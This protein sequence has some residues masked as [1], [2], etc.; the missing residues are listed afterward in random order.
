MLTP[1]TT[2][3][4]VGLC[5]LQHNPD[6]IDITLGDLIYDTAAGKERDVDVTVTIEDANGNIEAFKAVE[7]KAESKPLDVA[8]IEQLCLKLSDMPRVTQ[9][10]IFSRSGFTDGAISKAKAHSV[11]LYTIMPWDTPIGE[12]LL[13]FEGIGAPGEFLSST[14]SDL[15]YWVNYNVSIVIRKATKPIVFQNNTPILTRTGKRHDTF[16]DIQ[17]FIDTILMRSTGILCMQEPATTILRTFP[18]T[19]YLPDADYLAGPAWPHTHTIDVTS[20]EAYIE[21]ENDVFR[22]DEVTIAGNLQWRQR[23]LDPEFFI[24][25]NV[26][27]KK[28]FAG[29]AI[30]DY[31]ANDGRMFAM[32]FPETGR[33]L[34]I[35]QICIPEKQKNMLRNLKIKY[36]IPECVK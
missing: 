2:Q 22:I 10:S 29:A 18:Y 23:K 32:V 3:Y 25:K 33:T 8:I 13:D 15:L 20:D 24:L 26:Y 17:K 36:G 7:V 31:G 21:L 4:L 19:L 30:A 35:H 14:E 6:A 28:I 12:D 27:T 11:D 5:C 9:K 16:F 34:G 1:M